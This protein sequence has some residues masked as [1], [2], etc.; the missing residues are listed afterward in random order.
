MSLRL[1]P[2]TKYL[3]LYLA[4]V[5]RSI[6]YRQ[7][8]ILALT[9]NLVWI[10][11]PYFLWQAIFA[12]NAQIENFDWERMRTYIL[13]AYAIN[14]LLTFRT[15]SQMMATIRTGE[16]AT[17]LMRPVDYLKMQLAGALGAATVEALLCIPLTLV[18]GVVWL[19]IL[20]PASVLNAALFFVS[21]ALGFLVKF[22]ISYITGLICFW[23]LN[24]LGLLWTRAALTNIFS[25]AFIPLNFLPGVLQ[26]AA[27]ILPF[28]AVV[29]TPIQVYFGDVQGTE[30]LGV[31]V[32]QVFWCV[33]LWLLAR[34]FWQPSVRTLT[35]QGG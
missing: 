20:P 14:A 24:S 1:K 29:F 6:A 23:T 25:G 9:A 8:I 16:I 27:W 7:T 32:L 22:L 18:I 12:E 2:R 17:E 35:V 19:D 5:Q 31:L 4:A 26:A 28:R 21:V 30:L 3:S 10:I 15:E 13:L 34:L 11:I 33:A